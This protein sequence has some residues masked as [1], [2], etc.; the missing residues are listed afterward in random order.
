M[1]AGPLKY[2]A[3]R[4]DSVCK[5]DTND[6]PLRTNVAEALLGGGGPGDGGEVLDHSTLES[7]VV[8]WGLLPRIWSRMPQ[9]QRISQLFEAYHPAVTPKNRSIAMPFLVTRKPAASVET[10]IRFLLAPRLT[11]LSL[12]AQSQHQ[13]QHRLQ[14]H[15]RQS[16]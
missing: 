6:R 16:R 4:L 14:D 7:T 12:I 2:Q 3:Y 10:R 9:Q 13:S 5:T 11:C 1:A 15:Q 8:L